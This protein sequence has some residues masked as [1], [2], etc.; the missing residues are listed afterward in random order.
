MGS[1]KIMDRTGHT[2]V[3]YD[4]EGPKE[5]LQVAEK[6]FN[7]KLAEGYAPFVKL[8]DGSYVQVQRER[9]DAR[10]DYLMIPQ[11]VGG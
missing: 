8:E 5:Q 11:V 7:E 1:M 3:T 4:F 10:Q 2:E 6:T 9:F